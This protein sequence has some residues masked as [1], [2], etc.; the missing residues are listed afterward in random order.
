MLCTFTGWDGIGLD[1][2]GLD[3]VGLNRII[4]VQPVNM[5]MGMPSRSSRVGVSVLACVLGEEKP[6]NG[7][8]KCKV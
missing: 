8:Y 3:W 5:S 2:I 1:W 6:V 7:A 4:S